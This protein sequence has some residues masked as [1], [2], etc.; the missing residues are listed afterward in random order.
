MLDIFI[1]QYF[2]GLECKNFTELIVMFRVIDEVS[3]F[4]VKTMVLTK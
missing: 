1:Y 2:L 4:E 3:Q